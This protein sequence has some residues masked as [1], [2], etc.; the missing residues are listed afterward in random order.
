MSKCEFCKKTLH[1]NNFYNIDNDFCLC[2]DCYRNLGDKFH[3]YSFKPC[4]VFK[5]IKDRKK[6]LHVGI[7]LEIQTN[8]F[9]YFILFLHLFRNKNIYLKRDGSLN[10]YGIEFVSMPMTFSY[11]INNTF[12]MLFEKFR[13]YNFNN[14]DNCGLHFHLDKEYLNQ[15]DI[16]KIDYMVNNWCSQLSS[17]G[18]REYVNSRYCRVLYKNIDKYGIDTEGSRYVAC[19]LTNRDTVELRFCKSTSDYYTFIKRVSLIFSLVDIAKQ[20]TY[21]QL[22]ESDNPYDILAHAMRKYMR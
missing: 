15:M 17:I 5:G 6:H 11:I 19:N 7:E 13:E 10:E 22:M 1:T 12:E 14:T 4:P 3:T 18:G 21:K 8:K 9:K 16:A 2:V 20:Y